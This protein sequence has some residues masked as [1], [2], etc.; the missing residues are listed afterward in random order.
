MPSLEASKIVRSNFDV[1]LNIV[2]G[3]NGEK[4]HRHAKAVN[5]FKLIAKISHL[6]LFRLCE[7]FVKIRFDRLY[8][9]Y[10]IATNGRTME[11][12]FGRRNFRGANRIVSWW[13]TDRSILAIKYCR[14]TFEML[15]VA[16]TD[17]LYSVKKV[18]K[19]NAES[20]MCAYLVTHRF[21]NNCAPK[22]LCKVLESNCSM[23]SSYSTYCIFE[24]CSFICFW[25]VFAY[26]RSGILIAL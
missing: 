13:Y 25:S 7:W 8:E 3:Q 23:K 10:P 2:L 12:K 22:A 17:T 1:A 6:A 24:T 16:R 26:N 14:I 21:H 5:Y 9:N 15:F 18:W 4:P 19:S 11:Q 20:A